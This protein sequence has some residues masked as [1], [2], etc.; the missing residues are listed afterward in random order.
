MKTARVVI[1]LSG[2]IAA[3]A[4]VAAGTGVLWQG[5]GHYDFTTL[6]GEVVQMQGGGLYKFETVSGAAQLIGGDIVTLFVAVPLLI[7][8]SLLYARGS[9]RSKVLLS[10]TLAYFLY[11]YT[12]LA[13]LAAYNELFLVYVALFSMS[14]FAFVMT[15]LEIDVT[16]LPDH[17][18]GGFPRRGIAGFAL[19]VGAVV[20]L[21]WLGRIVPALMSGATPFGLESYTTLVIQVLDLGIMVPVAFVG[22]MLLLKKA[23]FGYLLS[24]IVLVKG[25]SLGAAVSAMGLMQVLA[26]V[27]VSVVEAAVFPLFTVVDTAFA[28]LMFKSLQEAPMEISPPHLEPTRTG[29]RTGAGTGATLISR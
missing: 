20:A 10:G 16:S 18:S 17:F 23:P 2:L 15:L 9:L 4:T 7:M 28:V 26:G 24:S 19:F 1:V 25:F 6:R 27:Q 14:L 29:T 21:M 12:S 5:G 3:L 22:G 11:T 13:M 8:A